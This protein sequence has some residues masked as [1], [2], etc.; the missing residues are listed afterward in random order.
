MNRQESSDP[1]LP[2]TWAVWPAAQRPAQAAGLAAMALLVAVFCSVS[3]GGIAYGLVAFVVVLAAGAPFLLPC[4]YTLDSQG[5]HVRGVFWR[6]SRSWDQVACYL[7]GPDFIAVSTQAEP[8][9]RA[10]SDGLILRLAGNGDE[11]EAALSRY[12]PNWE[13]PPEAP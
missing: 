10:I 13:R 7:R 6:K 4:T 3:F 1:A 8:T 12:I 9:H 2:L 5:L 11:V